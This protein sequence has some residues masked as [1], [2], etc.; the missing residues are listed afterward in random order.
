MVEYRGL[1]FSLIE[2]S[3]AFRDFGAPLPFAIAHNTINGLNPFGVFF[4]IGVTNIFLALV[5]RLAFPAQPQK[6]IGARA[7]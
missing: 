5:Y 2:F 4:G 7:S 1:E 3:G 6:A